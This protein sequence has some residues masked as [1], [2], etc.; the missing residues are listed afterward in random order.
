MSYFF[1]VWVAVRR[2]YSHYTLS[3][4]HRAY[5]GIKILAKRILY[6]KSTDFHWRMLTYKFKE[7]NTFG[8][9]SQTGQ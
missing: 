3:P 8:K 4:T 1:M 6:I 9:N 5:S 7:F 2:E